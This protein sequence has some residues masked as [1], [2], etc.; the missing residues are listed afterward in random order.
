MRRPALLLLACLAL[1]LGAEDAMDSSTRPLTSNESS[2]VQQYGRQMGKGLLKEFLAIDVDAIGW[3]L[4]RRL[5]PAWPG[6][7]GGAHPANLALSEA[8]NAPGIGAVHGPGFASLYA[9]DLRLEQYDDL[10]RLQSDLRDIP[11]AVRFDADSAFFGETFRVKTTL[12]MP[13]S[14][15]DEL[16][17]EA[18]MPVP[19]LAPAWIGDLLHEGGFNGGWDLKSSYANRLGSSSVITGLGTQWLKIWSLNYE[20]RVRFGQDAYEESQWLRLG[21]DF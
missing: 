14:W 21:R 1:R 12:F 8:A 9:M 7:R 16:R 19:N 11:F 17:L 20:M 6:S 2:E 15:K 18:K 10:R 5:A 4:Q 3:S 13:L